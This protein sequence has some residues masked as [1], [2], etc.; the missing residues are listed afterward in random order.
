ML[1]KDIYTGTSI[2]TEWPAKVST[3]LSES[4]TLIVSIAAK[5]LVDV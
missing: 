3:H 4:K 1:F 5:E 2:Y